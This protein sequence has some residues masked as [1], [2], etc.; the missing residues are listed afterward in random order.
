MTDQQAAEWCSTFRGFHYKLMDLCHH[1]SCRITLRC[2]VKHFK[3]RM[4]LGLHTAI[5][6]RASRLLNTLTIP[7][8]RDDSPYLHD[9]M[10]Q[11]DTLS[12]VMNLNRSRISWFKKKRAKMIQQ[13]LTDIEDAFFAYNHSRVKQEKQLQEQI[14]SYEKQWGG[15]QSD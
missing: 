2:P 6:W 3:C 13:T 12:Y 10:K 8:F 1:K 15:C 11:I 5:A 9:I 4:G 7:M 14:E